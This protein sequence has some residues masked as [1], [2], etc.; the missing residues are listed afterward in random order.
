MKIIFL[1]TETRIS[2][3]KNSAGTQR[4]FV[5]I[6]KHSRTTGFRCYN[7][8]DVVD[9]MGQRPTSATKDRVRKPSKIS[10]ILIKNLISRQLSRNNRLLYFCLR[11]LYSVVGSLS[12]FPLIQF[13][14]LSGDW[15]GA[16]TY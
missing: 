15:L 10:K 12:G 14:H 4:C 11:L 16:V 3:K 2:E 1:S 7:I 13:I 9:K 8:K 5:K 6:H